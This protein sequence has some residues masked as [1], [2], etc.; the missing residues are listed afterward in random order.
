MALVITV[1]PLFGDVPIDPEEFAP[2]LAA[3]YLLIQDKNDWLLARRDGKDH[4]I[5]PAGPK[6]FDLWV[7]HY[8]GTKTPGNP[9]GMYVDTENPILIKSNL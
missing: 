6:A 9:R 7:C 2:I 8:D 3:G 5:R 4:M 1:G